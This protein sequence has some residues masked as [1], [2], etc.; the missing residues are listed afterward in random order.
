M[1]GIQCVLPLIDMVGSA[2]YPVRSIPD[3]AD[4]RGVFARIGKKV[5][6][7]G[8]LSYQRYKTLIDF[9]IKAIEL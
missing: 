4:F 7:P 5:F 3:D 6:Y 8:L 2:L 9:M 1:E